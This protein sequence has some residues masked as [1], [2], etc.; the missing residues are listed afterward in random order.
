MNS[1]LGYAGDVSCQECF[2][3]LCN[4]PNSILVDVRTIAE[5]AFVGVP[6]LSEI[7]KDTLKISWRQ[8]PTM[9]INENFVVDLELMGGECISKESTKIFFICRS[10]ARSKEAAISATS[11][12]FKHCFNVEEGFEGSVNEHGKRG[13]FAGWKAENLP[14]IQY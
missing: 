12:G 7:E 4:E 13:I 6:D 9:Q 5:W 11:A 10:G 8:Y 1:K 3:V 2:E 14:W